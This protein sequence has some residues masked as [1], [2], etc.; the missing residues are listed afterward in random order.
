MT[1]HNSRD[2]RELQ[3]E[4]G[5]NRPTRGKFQQIPNCIHC[6]TKPLCLVESRSQD[7][8]VNAGELSDYLTTILCTHSQLFL[9]IERENI[10]C[11]ITV[12]YR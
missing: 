7:A 11:S 1:R 3:G 6:V 12:F 5:L 10:R 9:D 2:P 4:E 8:T